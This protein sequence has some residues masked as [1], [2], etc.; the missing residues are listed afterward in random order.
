MLFVRVAL[1]LTLAAAALACDVHESRSFANGPTAP[2]PPPTAAPPPTAPGPP[3]NVG[4]GSVSIRSISPASG[5][6]IGVRQCPPGPFT[7]FTTLCTDRV[8]AAIDVQVE[9]DIAA[10]TIFVRFFDALRDCGVRP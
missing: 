5:A 9:R 2:T 1:L 3:T 8:R 4:N 10:A 6:V 7:T